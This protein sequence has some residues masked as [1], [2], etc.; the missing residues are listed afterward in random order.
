MSTYV[1]PLE[2]L[3]RANPV[4]RLAALAPTRS[5][6]PAQR[7]LQHLLRRPLPEVIA[8]QLAGSGGPR[9]SRRLLV[10]GGVAGAVALL[11]AA[12][13]VVTRPAENPTKVAC[14][15]AASLSADTA[16]ASLSG[17]VAPVDACVAP[18]QDGSFPA[19]GV[20]P[21]AACV[22][23]SGVIGVFPGEASVCDAL[24]LARLATDGAASDTVSVVQLVDTLTAALAAPNC[25]DV[26]TAEVLV[27]D[28]LGQLDLVGWT[29]ISPASNG[30]GRPCTSI[31]IDPPAR[32]IRLVP[33]P[34]PG[35]S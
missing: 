12:A 31:D 6:V 21:L 28:R 18:W 27:R 24:G 23:P 5:Y 10:V 4:P 13:W 29:L 7:T 34:A 22:L 17:G 16:A 25:L 2:L 3:A 32:T 15:A 30:Q 20:P 35:A 9:R 26:A 8:Q 14:Y 19:G 1:D 33:I 11:A